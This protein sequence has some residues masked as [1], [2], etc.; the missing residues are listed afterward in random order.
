MI[1]LAI[2]CLARQHIFK[3]LEKELNLLRG[4]IL[5]WLDTRAFN[6]YVES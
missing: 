1:A 6:G 2:E 5:K 3:N 4:V